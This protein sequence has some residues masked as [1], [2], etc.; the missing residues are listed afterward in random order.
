MSLHNLGGL[1]GLCPYWLSLWLSEDIVAT[2]YFWPWMKSRYFI[3]ASLAMKF[4]VSWSIFM[5]SSQPSWIWLLGP[6][7]IHGVGVGQS[8]Q[9]QNGG[10][11]LIS[12]QQTRWFI[13]QVACN[14][15]IVLENHLEWLKAELLS[16]FITVAYTFGTIFQ[17]WFVGDCWS[18]WT[19]W[20]KGPVSILYLKTKQKENPTD[21]QCMAV[22]ENVATVVQ[23][24]DDAAPE[25]VFYTIKIIP[26]WFRFG[27]PAIGN[28]VLSW[29]ECRDYLRMLL[30]LKDSNHI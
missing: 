18:A 16:L 13:S 20:G 4:M 7:H 12:W 25:Q 21:T 29:K 1:R 19:W 8:N 14:H 24:V 27:H 9:H 10:G 15:N 30:E 22:R 17:K 26:Q 23:D 2:T 5:V 3:C 28:M 6:F 11:I